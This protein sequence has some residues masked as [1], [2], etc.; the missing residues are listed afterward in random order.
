M[1]Y[2]LIM[3]SVIIF[4]GCFAFKNIYRKVRG[5]S[6]QATL[7]FSFAGGIAS[8]I[9]LTILNGLKF[10]FTPFT[11]VMALLKALNGFGFSYCSL[12]ALGRINLSLY[13]LFS[14]LGGMVLPFL[15]G[16]IFYDEDFTVAKA[17]CLVFIVL[18]LLITVEGRGGK[19]GGVI[20]YIGIFVLNGLS[21]VLSKI[22]EASSYEKTSARGYSILICLC[23]IVLS[24]IVLLIMRKTEAP[25]S[26]PM[27]LGIGAA[28][29]ITN[30]IANLF[31]VIALAHVDASVQYP[32]V[33]G[34]VMIVS[35]AICF[36]GKKKPSKKELI[37]VS[38]AFLGML[39]LFIIPA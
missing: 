6:I 25:K 38:L 29:G 31:L 28:S 19:K 21:G 12:K 39:A 23:S 33:T 14:M 30:K 1:Y 18:A 7:E 13:S 36:F 37:S 20:Y 3:L 34:G 5:G 32:M 16:I 4:S 9:F 11:L 24:A 8:I 17:V 2:G 35:T 15:Q 27:S 10:E 22:F 26:T